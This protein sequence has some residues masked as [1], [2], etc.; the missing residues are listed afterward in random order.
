MSVTLKQ[1]RECTGYEIVPGNSRGMSLYIQFFHKDPKHKGYL[2]K[3]TDLVKKMGNVLTSK[4]LRQRASAE[5]SI[6][7]LLYQG[8]LKGL[9]AGYLDDEKMSAVFHYLDKHHFIAYVEFNEVTG[10][11]TSSWGRL[12]IKTQDISGYRTKIVNQP[13][14]TAYVLKDDEASASAL[15][16]YAAEVLKAKAEAK[17]KDNE[18]K[19]EAEEKPQ[20]KRGPKSDAVPV[21]RLEKRYNSDELTAVT[22]WFSRRCA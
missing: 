18:A 22:G 12:K 7:K 6:E 13:R 19:A 10:L 11:S 9:S 20:K 21:G 17:A 3:V 2:V 15:E 5:V 1:L 14:P 8:S 4:G 16:R